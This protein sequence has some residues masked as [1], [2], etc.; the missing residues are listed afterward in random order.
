VSDSDRDDLTETTITTKRVYEGRV[1]SLRV[2]EVQ[3]PSGRRTTREVVEHHGAVAAV[4]L[5]ADGE[6]LMVRQW[7]YAVGAATL[8]IPAGTLEPGETAEQCIRRELVEEIG[9]RAGRIEPM[10]EFYVSPGYSNEL[11]R[12]F[13]ATELTPESAE[14][15]EDEE[16][17]VVVVH[18][19]EA[20]EMCR[21][22]ELRDG[23]TIAALLC[24][25]D[26]LGR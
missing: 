8:E 6:V 15:D 1:L 16:L 3:M 7:R 5:T 23:K 26:R 20:L 17:R 21:S 19:A 22:G 2:D 24:V 11:I 14:A 4:P 10:V 25:A 18:L 9:H 13:L 12:L